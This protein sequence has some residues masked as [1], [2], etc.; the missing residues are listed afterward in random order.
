[1]LETHIWPR[2]ELGYGKKVKDWVIRSQAP[3][4]RYDKSMEKV[5]RLNGCGYYMMV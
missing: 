1:M 2:L 4:A 3:V 5:Q